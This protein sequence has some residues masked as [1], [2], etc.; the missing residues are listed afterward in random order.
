[1]AGIVYCNGDA[2][3]PAGHG[4]RIICHVCNDIGRWG[5][6]FVVAISKRWPQP[7]A[8]FR[9]WYAQGEA[10]GFRLGA[11][12]L[13]DVEPTLMVANMIGQRGI[14]PA[15][16]VP[17][18]R[19]DALGECLASLATRAAELRA[20]VHMPRI[21][22]GLAGGSWDEVEAIITATLVAA[23]VPVQVYDF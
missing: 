23:A 19:Y 4:P 22:C 2:T 13:V 17:P 14:K 8:E 10:G 20:S 15:G 5:K 11:I 1:M 18:I 6:G 16:G 12:Q 7:E 21:G 3:T 9:A